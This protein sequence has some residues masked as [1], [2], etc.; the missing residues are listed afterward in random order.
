MTDLDK[1]DVT[2]LVFFMGLILKHL[3]SLM[4]T[5]TDFQQIAPQ[6]KLVRDAL[7]DLIAG[8]G[9]M[10]QERSVDIATSGAIAAL[11]RM[12]EAQE[13]ER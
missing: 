5:G 8:N 12:K 9:V 6:I 11:K 1:N 4:L 10:S 3:S 2:R 13:N 7:D